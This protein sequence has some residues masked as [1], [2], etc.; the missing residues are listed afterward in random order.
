M[1]AAAFVLSACAM[2]ALSSEEVSQSELLQYSHFG[3]FADGPVLAVGFNYSEDSGDV[4]F[5][6]QR[7]GEALA[8][9]LVS[10]T[11][12]KRALVPEAPGSAMAV[13]PD[14]GA[15]LVAGAKGTV[16]RWDWRTGAMEKF[17]AAGSRVL[18][19][20]ASSD[21]QALAIACPRSVIIT[22]L[23]TGATLAELSDRRH[24]KDVFFVSF[25]DE[26]R[27]LASLSSDQVL[28]LWD[29]QKQT[30]LRATQESFTELFSADYSLSGLF[31]M[32]ATDLT[33]RRG[34]LVADDRMGRWSDKIKVMDLKQATEI[35]VLDGQGQNASITS[36]ALS[37]D[38]KYLATGGAQ[39]PLRLWDILRGDEL[40][41]VDAGGEVNDLAF[42]PNGKWLAAATSRGV[43]V[44]RT[45]GI[46]PDKAFT[47]LLTG[48]KFVLA[49]SAA[50]LLD[51]PRPTSIGF[52]GFEAEPPLR[53]AAR[54][55]SALLQEQLAAAAGIRMA[56]RENL[57][58]IL[59][60]LE[61][62]YSGM[63]DEKKAVRIGQLANTEKLLLGELRRL[64][65]S[66]ILT[67]KLLDVAS[68]L[69]EGVR[70]LECRQCA[71]E[72]LSRA[73]G[74]LGGALVKR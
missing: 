42:S 23:D 73:I 46:V 62:Q 17:V 71:E 45:H 38:N 49:S 13:L 9:D 31:V 5:A 34:A 41:Q 59:K 55:V 40:A 65:G 18:A 33:A 36:I 10:R 3:D 15:V 8:L 69:V 7:K 48:R 68:G 30:P 72:D 24:K 2:T 26:S 52:L 19:L 57:D 35:K 63:T 56:D 60:E 39:G 74:V 53:D 14:D 29:L 16:F 58:R 66:M 4:L 50:P 27:S 20:S 12:R 70:T 44:W 43:R 64:G 11:E 54:G 67:V 25:V 47:A 37:P 28:I 51:F 32:G 6:V 22:R 21:G 61:L 1:S